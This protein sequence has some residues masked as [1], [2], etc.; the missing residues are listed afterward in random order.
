MANNNRPLLLGNYAGFVT[1]AAALIIDIV[2]VSIAVIAINWIIS[3]PLNYFFSFD[4]QSCLL[5]TSEHNTVVVWFCR[6]IQLLW[7]AVILTTAPLYFAIL[8]SLNGQTIGKYVMGLRVVRFD[9][10]RMTFFGSLLR[11]FAYFLSALPFGLGFFVVLVDAQRRA[12]H[13]RIAGTCVVYSW[14]ARQNEFL[15]DRVRRRIA[16][17]DRS[18]EDSDGLIL[19]DPS[20]KLSSLYELVV[21]ATPN[22]AQ[23]QTM[24]V[25]L[26]NSVASDEITIINTAV[27]VKGI[28]GKLGVVGVSDL[29]L[30]DSMLG[31][32][33]VALRVPQAQLDRIR[34]DVPND[35]FVIVMLIKDK[36]L[37]STLRIVSRRAPA[38]LAHY[39][40]GEHPEMMTADEGL[41]PDIVS[42]PGMER[43]KDGKG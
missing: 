4:V 18:N 8:T 40:V 5:S 27:M 9:G 26:E 23:L 12:L 1:R 37:D 16:P 29:T 30:G 39:D 21:I 6:S 24:L 15:V 34:E 36:W 14:R 31:M 35:S 33:D 11:W 13:D 20:V 7:L 10:Q 38:M 3:L 2:I 28:D 19:P 41:H 42:V 17:G 32:V 43:G 25:L 22:Y